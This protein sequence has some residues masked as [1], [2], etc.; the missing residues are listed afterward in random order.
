MFH[1]K[2]QIESWW[3]AFGGSTPALQKL[4]MMVLAQVSSACACER[5]WSAYD[6]IH[7][8]SRN[9]LKHQRADDLVYVFS[10]LRL[11]DELTSAFYADK[12]GRLADADAVSD[13]S[14][15]EEEEESED[16]EEGWEASEEEDDDDVEDGGGLAVG[17]EEDEEEE[18]EEEDEVGFESE[19]DE[20][21]RRQP[22]PREQPAP[23]AKPERRVARYG[24]PAAKLAAAVPT[25]PVAA[26]KR[27]ETTKAAATTSRSGR[28]LGVPARLRDQD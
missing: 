13:G 10:N 22:A 7:S 24:Q 14:G 4:A 8:R 11:V 21:E 12:G 9:K 19:S 28:V 23:Q 17:D 26:R 5:N 3:L 2:H 27:E 18:E 25:Q 6:F 15:A 20:E 16:P 1:K